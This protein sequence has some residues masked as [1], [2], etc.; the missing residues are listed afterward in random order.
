MDKLFL[1]KDYSFARVYQPLNVSAKL[2]AKTEDFIVEEHIPV[3]FSGEGEHCWLYVK[4]QGCN[5]DW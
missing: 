1:D 2:K 3:E 5:T 4:K